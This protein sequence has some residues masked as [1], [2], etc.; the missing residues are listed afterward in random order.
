MPNSEYSY[1]GGELHLFE[2]A[3]NWKRYFAHNIR[4][5]LGRSVIEVGAGIGANIGHLYDGQADWLC[6][7]SDPQLADRIRGRIERRELPP[8][9][10]VVV[11]TIGDLPERERATSVLYI[12][13]LEHIKDDASEVSIAARHLEIG[14]HLIA[15][16]P[17]HQWLFS[18]FD[19]AIG[20]HR[21]Y[22]AASCRT[23]T[24]PGLR[25]VALHYLDS[26]GTLASAVNKLLLRAHTPTK[27]QVLLWD[28]LMVPA[29]RCLD[30]LIRHRLGKSILA[31]WQ[32]HH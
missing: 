29:S 20:H 4:P 23:L 9:C 31:V 19:A 1:I 30:P 13:V 12:D 28:R 22:T 27:G 24:A 10:R 18:P 15:L 25:L 3:T 17:A 8:A 16:S 2:H 6:I 5:Y 21:R 7:E 11:G 32:K 14:G 26:I